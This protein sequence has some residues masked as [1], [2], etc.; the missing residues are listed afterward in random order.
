M[1]EKEEEEEEMVEEERSKWWF[2]Y[3]PLNQKKKMAQ[4]RQKYQIS[5]NEKNL[6]CRQTKRKLNHG[7]EK[8]E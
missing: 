1:V 4:K 2:N 8:T 5:L 7:E 6:F 3:R